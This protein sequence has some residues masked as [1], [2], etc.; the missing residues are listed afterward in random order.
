MIYVFDGT[1]YG[2]TTALVQAFKDEN[3]ILT[4][5][6]TQLPLGQTPVFVTANESVARKAAE[7]LT[8]FDR[9]AME[10][11]DVLLRS[12]EEDNEQVAFEYFKLLATLKRPI[13][14]ML[15]QPAVFKAVEYIKK[16][17]FEIH[18]FHG[19]VRFMETESGALY[20]PIEPDNDIA[21]LLVKH[22][23]ARLPE[24]PFVIHDTKR[25]KA[26]VYDG[27]NTFTAYL[28]HADVL[29]CADEQAWQSLWKNYYHAVNIPSRERL[30][31]M[32][33]YMPT[34]YWKYMPEKQETPKE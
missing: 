22:F 33:G 13:G 31:Q 8:S 17:R 30:K 23:K 1:M 15:A 27:E 34:R 16:V 6:Q 21:D 11:L 29:I 10:D 25:K 2:F 28:P 9:H 5:K 19:F 14:R 4:S 26:A 18:R 7:R 24:Y 12:G 32:R 3:A 20:A